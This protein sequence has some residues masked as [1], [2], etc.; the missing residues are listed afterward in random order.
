MPSKHKQ[1]ISQVHLLSFMY[2]EIIKMPRKPITKI[3]LRR[4]RY[5]L[6][7]QEQVLLTAEKDDGKIKEKTLWPVLK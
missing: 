4:F 6:S 7:V 3:F 2:K 1:E 5:G